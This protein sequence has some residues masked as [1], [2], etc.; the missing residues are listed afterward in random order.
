MKVALIPLLYEE[1]NFGGLLQFY[2]LQ[3]ALLKLDV[4]VE[5]LHV[6]NETNI[7]SEKNNIFW[8]KRMLLFPIRF[9]YRMKKYIFYHLNY[10][11]R[12]RKTKEFKKNFY[13]PVREYRRGESIYDAYICGSDQ[14]WNPNW[15][16]ERAFLAFAPKDKLRVIYA[17]SIGCESLTDYQKKCFKPYIEQLDAV[18]VREYS[19]KKILDSFITDKKI[20]VVLDPT[21][22][23]NAEEYDPLLV[24]I[25]Y[26]DYIF[27]YF[28][29]D[30]SPYQK[31]IVDLSNKLGKKIVNIACASFEKIESKSFGDIVVKDA[32]PRTFISLIKNASFVFTDSFHASVFS[33][34]FKREFFVF[35]RSRADMHGRLETLFRHFD[36]DSRMITS[37]DEKKLMAFK[38]ISS[39]MNL[40][41]IQKELMK[42]SYDFLKQSLA[43][44]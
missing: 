41:I 16:R 36:L 20:D 1:Y 44:N 34:I 5:I 25:D 38:K 32:D 21:L 4:T 10:G 7:C 17:A 43:L 40:E 15:A 26:T 9:F 35:K 31:S 28:L 37:I 39:K 18:S 23:L 6:K 3:K 19:A 27:T 8:G 30:C 42:K 29:G 11:K 12:I 33:I 14:I 24:D 22:L 13:L 2:A